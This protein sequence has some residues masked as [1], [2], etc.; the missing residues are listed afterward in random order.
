M[1]VEPSTRRSVELVSGTAI[2]NKMLVPDT[3]Y[4]GR[5][6]VARIYEIQWRKEKLDLAE[7]DCM[8][9]D[10]ETKSKI[11]MVWRAAFHGG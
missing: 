10:R 2:E 4:D 9:F 7:L 11:K 8:G 1:P 5:A 6:A 3:S